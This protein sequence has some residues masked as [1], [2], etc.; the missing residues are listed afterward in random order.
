MRY[1][2]FMTTTMLQ[3]LNS[4]SLFPL[5]LNFNNSHTFHKSQGV[6]RAFSK[7]TDGEIRLIFPLW[8][9]G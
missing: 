5:G 4:K 9:K 2:G 8:S 1:W 7:G 6:I 3:Q